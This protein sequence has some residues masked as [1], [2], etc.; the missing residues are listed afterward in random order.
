MQIEKAAA[1]TKKQAVSTDGLPLL[2]KVPA[3]WLDARRGF[4]LIW[5]HA[6]PRSG[7]HCMEH[8]SNICVKIIKAMKNAT[9]DPVASPPSPLQ[10]RDTV[11]AGTTGIEPVQMQL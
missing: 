4:R 1:A 2:G 7:L 11:M 6:P 3:T 10:L 8:I 5:P 9:A